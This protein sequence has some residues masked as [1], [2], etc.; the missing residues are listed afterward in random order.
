MGKPLERR[1]ADDAKAPFERQRI[2]EPELHEEHD[3][4]LTAQCEPTQGHERL[5]PERPPH[6]GKQSALVL[7]IDQCHPI[8]RLHG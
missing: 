4:G 6:G 3:H 8:L 2:L 7:L 5:E 1:Y